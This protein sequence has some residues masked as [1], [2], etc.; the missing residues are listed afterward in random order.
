MRFGVYFCRDPALAGRK[1]H[2]KTL[3]FPYN[4]LIAI[5]GSPDDSFF[6]K[7]QP[8]KKNVIQKRE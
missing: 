8:L 6:I 7:V 3:P 4:R 2:D 1:N 5:G